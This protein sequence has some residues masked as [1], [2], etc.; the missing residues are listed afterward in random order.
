MVYTP[1]LWRYYQEALLRY[2]ALLLARDPVNANEMKKVIDE[3]ARAIRTGQRLQELALTGS[4]SAPAALEFRL[5]DSIKSKV[6]GEFLALWK[7]PSTQTDDYRRLLLDPVKDRVTR[8]MVRLLLIDLL[9]GQAG[10]QEDFQRVCHII[11]TLND[12]VDPRP[13]EAHYALH[14]QRGLYDRTIGAGV[15]AVDYNLVWSSLNLRDL[16]EQASFALPG[17][18]YDTSS[19]ANYSERIHPWIRDRLTEADEA[20]RAGEDYL[21]AGTAQA[22]NARR[23]LQQAEATYQS[24]DETVRQLHEALSVRDRAAAELPYYTAWLAG[25][26]SHPDHDTIA[27]SLARDVVALWEKLHALTR[28][29]ENPG[30]AD[31]EK[32][33]KHLTD[34]KAHLDGDRE[35]GLAFQFQK[36]ARENRPIQQRNWHEI[37]D[38]LK[39]PFLDPD[40]RMALLGTL[41]EISADLEERSRDSA[42]QTPG[43]TEDQNKD[44]SLRAARRQ[45]NLALAILGKDT[46]EA[47]VVD[48]GQ[49]TALN[50][51]DQIGKG[52]RRTASET[53][54]L[55]ET[56]LKANLAPA[57]NLR[58]SPECESIPCI[59]I[60]LPP[61]VCTS[62]IGHET[63]RRFSISGGPRKTN[64]WS[65]PL[66][67]NE[68][69]NSRRWLISF[70]RRF[71]PF[72]RILQNPRKS[73]WSTS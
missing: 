11:V 31:F 66:S 27:A 10:S 46:P 38:L 20:R 43:L 51:G 40:R 5:E 28:I 73:P 71:A 13:V 55:T 47:K 25:K 6:E 57:V 2:E 65:R 34:I 3:T 36:N 14:L 23:H 45:S 48:N 8:Q 17:K 52:F 33:N 26:K 42:K 50:A 15:G 56:G 19:I 35:E 68:I 24:L 18:P 29:L 69:K 60:Q 16:S 39:V 54:G 67:S 72:R 32:L 30:S 64:G 1:H 9:L 41:H 7:E 12:A 22:A 44:L 62:R 70:R 21:F 63:T 53:V 61:G 59:I 37:Q 4:L 58:L 49:W